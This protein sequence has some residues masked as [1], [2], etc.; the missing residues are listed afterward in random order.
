MLSRSHMMKDSI[1]RMTQRRFAVTGAVFILMFVASAQAR[2]ERAVFSIRGYTGQADIVRSQGRL[3]VDIQDLAR[4][5]KGSLSF[6]GNNVVLTPAAGNADANLDST[7][8]SGFSPAFTR[9]AIEA[10]ASIREWGGI[11]EAMVENGYPVGKAMAG[12]TIRAYE[13]RAAD[14]VALAATAASTDSDYQGLDLLRNEL[15][16]V[17]AWSESF[18]SARNEMRAADLTTSEYPLRDDDEAQKIMHCGQFL[19]QMF[20]AG[21]FQDNPACH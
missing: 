17:H 13:G 10:M 19:A 21:G 4:I 18:V 14:N 16:N 15:N 5:T 2:P 8:G 11:L 9:A 12:N 1:L 7:S 6:E 3:L 20:A